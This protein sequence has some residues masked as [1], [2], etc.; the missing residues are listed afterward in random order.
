MWPELTAIGTFAAVTLA[1]GHSVLRLS[2]ARRHENPLVRGLETAA[3][4]LAS[5]SFLPVVLVLLHVP[6]HPLAYLGGSSAVL[7]AA[8]LARRVP[9]EKIAAAWKTPETLHALLL[10][11]LLGALF[12]TFYK[13]ATAYR[14]LE[15]DDSWLHAEATLYV[16]KAHTYSVEPLLRAMGGYANY[17]EPYPPTYDAMMGLMCQLDGSVSYTLKFF[18]VLLVTLAH[19]FFFLFCAEY[20][21]SSLK[22]LFATLVLIVL[23]SF[24]S[25]FIWSQSLALCVFPVAMVAVLRA[26]SDRT[27]AVPATVA[28][29][30]VMVTQPI[31]S[32]VFGVVLVL[33]LGSLFWQEAREAGRVSL[34]ACRRSVRGLLLGAA[35]LALSFLYWGPQ[36]AKWGLRGIFDLKGD[37]VTRKGLSTYA[38]PHYTLAE[39]V[40]PP[41]STRID[42]A[43]GWGLAVTIALLAGLVASVR[44]LPARGSRSLHLLAWFFVLAYAVFAPSVGLP[45]WASSRAWA[46]AAIPV[47]V[48]ATEGVFAVAR[49][50]AA[51][52][53]VRNAVLVVAALGVMATSAPAKIAV[54]TRPWPPGVQWTYAAEGRNMAPIDLLGFLEMRDQLPA[55][56]RVYS[57]CDSDA[58]VIGFDMDASPWD[59]AEAEFRR[60]GAAVTAPEALAFLDE[61]R[62]G[63]FTFDAACDNTWSGDARAHFLQS[64]SETGRVTWSLERR[65]FLLGKVS[66]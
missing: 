9:R 63:Y 52:A 42:Q 47:A 57:F 26:L 59:P 34:E 6:L 38:L 35:G 1:L 31:V 55:N 7:L 14:Y 29:G 23:P 19:G 27:W 4:G 22:G 30:S 44:A 13:G 53:S 41:I 25:H 66:R 3:V 39:T 10:L 21:Q 46:Y 48:L 49:I 20:L 54:Q 24:M 56:T 17:L 50:G 18:N 28:V 8:L 12:A 62:Y 16:A 65:G 61:H 64:L 32:F 15:D 33:F 36:L 58:R 45:A 51:K 40:V 2:G 60:R 37:E 5:F 43:T 11:V